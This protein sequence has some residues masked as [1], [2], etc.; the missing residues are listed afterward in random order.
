MKAS[1]IMVSQVITVQ[2]DSN[3]QEVAELLLKHRISAAPVVD[4]KGRLVGIVSEGDLLRRAEAGTERERSWWLRLL[5][6]RE[7]LAAEFVKEHSRKVADVMTKD[8]ITVA[9]DTPVS[10]IATTL[11]SNRIKRVPIIDKGKLVGIVSR[12]NL[13]Q[14]LAS[15]R[16]EIAVEK[17]MAD[18]ELRE[19]IMASLRAEPWV[20][21][22]LINV[23]VSD[24]TVDLWGV[25]DSHAE[26]Q[27]LRVAVEV[28]PG[29]RA[30]N[31]N[32]IVRP[33]VASGT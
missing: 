29:V 2:P 24:G 31:D 20:R 5:M 22:S 3:V 6:G 11:E 16:K 15:M 19:K 12:A 8:V 26:K 23:T 13:L 10:E 9:P 33:V 14:A 32:V 30:V 7:I 27:A 17:P 28:T 18:A 21:P 25:V 4:A 1:D